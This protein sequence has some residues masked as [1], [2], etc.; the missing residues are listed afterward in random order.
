MKILKKVFKAVLIII[1]ILVLGFIGL[2]VY[3]IVTDY[4]PAEKEMIAQSDK[5]SL[6]DDSISYSLLTW[7]IGYAGLDKEMDFSR[8]EVLK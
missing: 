2:I 8:M 5:P 4:K 3:A 1:G 7:N 6:L